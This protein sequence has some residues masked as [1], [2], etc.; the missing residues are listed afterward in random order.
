MTAKARSTCRKCGQSLPARTPST[1][2]RP[3]DYC[4]TGCRRAAEHELRRLD[5]QLLTAEAEITALRLALIP[6]PLTGLQAR[7]D[8][9]TSETTRLEAR[10]AHLLDDNTDTDPKE[11]PSDAQT[12]PTPIDRATRHRPKRD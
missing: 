1:I 7:L 6:Q 8:W 5:T 9:W 12:E 3:L 10:M 11:P 2:G 4:S